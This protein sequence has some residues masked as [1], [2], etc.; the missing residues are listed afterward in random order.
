[1]TATLFKV[2]ERVQRYLVPADIA[3]SAAA[4][5]GSTTTLVDTVHLA[6]GASRGGGLFEFLWLAITHGTSMYPRRITEGGD[7]ETSGTLT[8]APAAGATVTAGDLYQ[9][10]TIDPALVIGAID[11]ALRRMEFEERVPLTVVTDQLLYSLA[12]DAA[13]VER[14]GQFLGLEWQDTATTP[15]Q[16]PL[17]VSSWR[18]SRDRGVFTLNLGRSYTLGRDTVTLVTLRSYWSLDGTPQGATTHIAQNAAWV[19]TAPLEWLAAEVAVELLEKPVTARLVA[20]RQGEYEQALQE[21]RGIVARYRAD[22]Q[23]DVPRRMFGRTARAYD[24]VGQWRW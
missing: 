6:T 12:A 1:M 3:I 4:T 10:W 14:K 13:W 7:N 8:F 11:L 9:T 5:G 15:A 16:V 2:M 23:P 24:P 17:D 19:T 22:Q 18:L 20:V 21:A